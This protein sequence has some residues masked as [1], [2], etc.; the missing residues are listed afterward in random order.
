MREEGGS[1]R[2]NASVRAYDRRQNE[3]DHYGDIMQVFFL[4][5]LFFDDKCWPLPCV[6][7]STL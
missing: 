6:Q 4:G 5:H 7:A 1:S 2:F 3:A